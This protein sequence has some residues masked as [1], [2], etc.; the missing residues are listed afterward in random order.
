ME[1]SVGLRA[2]RQISS[3]PRVL[4]APLRLFLL[5]TMAWCLGHPSLAQ[6][7]EFVPEGIL[8]VTANAESAQVYI[9]DVLVGSAPIIKVLH[10]GHHRVRVTHLSFAAVE[11]RV[12]VERDT[13][14]QLD[15][16]LERVRSGLTVLVDVA[17]ARVFLDGRQVGVGDVV[18]DPVRPGRHQL[19]V[20][21]QGF[22]PHEVEVVL[23]QQS[24]STLK[25]ALHAIQGSVELS[26]VPLG[27]SVSVDGKEMGVTPL[28]LEGLRPGDHALE[29]HAP[30][31]ATVFHAL[32]VAE[33][34]RSQLQLALP[35]EGGSLHLG[36]RPAL[37]T[38]SLNGVVVGEGSHR[39]RNLAPGMYELR[40][41][42]PGYL[43][44]FQTVEITAGKV[45]RLRL[46]MRPFA[47]LN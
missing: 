30:G 46:R 31:R 44:V 32:Q 42:A 18:L 3:V 4:R 47:A 5:V 43:D 41:T 27:A 19:V 37:A 24:M 14:V 13:T 36:V 7:E 40:L 26:T 11:Q 39:L 38:T 25:V 15:V 23:R 9:D 34:K 10:A 6:G 33:G 12:L 21:A 45:L 17:G 8:E 28:H 1:P 29:L 22:R 16:T 20:E 35:L 2:Q